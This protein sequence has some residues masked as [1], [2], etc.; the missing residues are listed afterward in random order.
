[1]NQKHPFVNFSKQIL[2][3][4]VI[5]LFLLSIPDKGFAWGNLTAHPTINDLADDLFYTSS[6]NKDYYSEKYKFG[7]IDREWP[8]FSGRTIYQWWFI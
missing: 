2:L 3:M 4:L 6:L 1:M 8:E 5:T 7:S